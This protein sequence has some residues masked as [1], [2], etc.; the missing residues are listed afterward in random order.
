MMTIKPKSG[1]AI[2]VMAGAHGP[3]DASGGPALSSSRTSARP[4]CFLT[5]THKK[6]TYGRYLFQSCLF[7][8]IESDTPCRPDTGARPRRRPAITHHICPK[9]ASQLTGIFAPKGAMCLYSY[10]KFIPAFRTSFTP[11]VV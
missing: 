2:F 3:W 1:K 11:G 4:E 6:Y 9:S 8:G 5:R 7:L 10:L